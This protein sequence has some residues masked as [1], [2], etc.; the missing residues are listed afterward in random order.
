M[1]SLRHKIEMLIIMR[2]ILLQFYY[3]H[4]KIQLQSFLALFKDRD[5][6]TSISVHH[7]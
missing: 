4:A 6:N 2:W 1:Y 7:F 3:Q 5:Y